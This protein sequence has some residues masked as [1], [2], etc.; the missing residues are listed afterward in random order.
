MSL[1][2]GDIVLLPFSWTDLTNYKVRPALV[3]SEDNF[4]KK[5]NDAVFMFITSKRYSSDYDFYL[6]SKDPSFNKTGLKTS[7]TFRISKIITLEQ[8]LAK[9]HLG[10]L[11]KKI[12]K[13]LEAGLS[14]LLNI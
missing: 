7:S 3:I 13:K 14:L 2:R 5:N 10:Y 12:L 11:D 8:K 4:N 1:K 9:R 6:D